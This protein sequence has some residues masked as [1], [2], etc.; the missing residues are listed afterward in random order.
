M[1]RTS[2]YPGGMDAL[3]AH[4]EE[5]RDALDYAQGESLAA[6]DVDLAALTQQQ[7]TG[8]ARDPVW[9]PPMRSSYHRKCYAL[10]QELQGESE[11]VFRTGYWCRTCA[12][13]ASLITPP[14]CL[15][16][17]GVNR[18]IICYST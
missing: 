11:L 18:A 9:A 3:L 8:P 1:S 17:C 13:A 5:R 16:G 6:L 14:R 7:V 2:I 12:N 10:R 4:Y 15:C